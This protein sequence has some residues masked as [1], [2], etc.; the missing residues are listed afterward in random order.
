MV[1]QHVKRHRMMNMQDAHPEDMPSAHSLVQGALVLLKASLFFPDLCE[2]NHVSSLYPLIPA[3]R[4][5]SLLIRF[6]KRSMQLPCLWQKFHFQQD[7]CQ[8]FRVRPQCRKAWYP[9]F[10][11]SC[12]EFRKQIYSVL[13][14]SVQISVILLHVHLCL[15]VHNVPGIPV[16]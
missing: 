11:G 6:G 12:S 13:D 14:R 2:Y 10:W 5:Q 1:P 8:S 15:L 3:Y 4:Y 7:I 9:A 16:S